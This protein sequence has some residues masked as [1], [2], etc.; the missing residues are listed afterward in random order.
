MTELKQMKEKNRTT[1]LLTTTINRPSFQQFSILSSNWIFV[2]G[3]YAAFRWKE[4]KAGEN[5]LS[6]TPSSEKVCRPKVM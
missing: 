6:K 1:E 3:K 5:F 4:K 2:A